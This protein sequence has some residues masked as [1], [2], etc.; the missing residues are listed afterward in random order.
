MTIQFTS[1]TCFFVFPDPKM[2]WGGHLHHPKPHP[3]PLHPGRYSGVVMP[4]IYKSSLHAQWS[5]VAPTR[6][7]MHLR[8]EIQ[9]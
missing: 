8:M 2:G 1:K 5:L 9:P 6:G 3:V 4:Y 7:F